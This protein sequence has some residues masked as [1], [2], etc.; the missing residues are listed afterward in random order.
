[1]LCHYAQARCLRSQRIRQPKT[2]TVIDL[3]ADI[4][5]VFSGHYPRKIRRGLISKE[6][7]GTSNFLQLCV[8]MCKIYTQVSVVL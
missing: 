2:A 4:N 5:Q 3:R 1:M 8:C 7:H 6:E